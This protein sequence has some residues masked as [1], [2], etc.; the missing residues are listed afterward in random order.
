MIRAAILLTAAATARAADPVVMDLYSAGT[1]GYHTYRI[2]AIEAAPDGS[3]VAFAEARKYNADDP[4]FG[5]QD[6][7]LVFKRSTNNGA[8]WTSMTVL[9]DPGELWSAANAATANTV[10]PPPWTESSGANDAH[11]RQ[12]CECRPGTPAG[13]PL[14]PKCLRACSPAPA[15]AMSSA[16]RANRTIGLRR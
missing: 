11:S 16:S 15:C 8:S 3:L 7:D 4:G 1:G 6:I 9:E 12:G 13:S 10:T 14:I 2:P 5:R